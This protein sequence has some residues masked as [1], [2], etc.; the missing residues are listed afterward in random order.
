MVWLGHTGFG[1]TDAI[2][3]AGR[4]VAKLFTTDQLLVAAPHRAL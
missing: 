1:E 4:S 2:D 3:G